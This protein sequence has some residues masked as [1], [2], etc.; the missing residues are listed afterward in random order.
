[1]IES[2][3]RRNNSSVLD[4]SGMGLLFLS[5]EGGNLAAMVEEIT[6]AVE[7]LGLG[8]V[9]SIRNFENGFALKIKRRHMANRDAQ[10]VDDRLAAANAFTANDVRMI[11]FCDHSH[12]RLL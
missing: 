11:G 8:E 12:V 1:M 4:E 10:A 6:Q 9:Q 7:N 3:I 2:S 5:D